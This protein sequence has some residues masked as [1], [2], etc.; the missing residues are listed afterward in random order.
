M[1]NS[2]EL[3]V[4]NCMMVYGTI[5]KEKG[6][7]VK[8]KFWGADAISLNDGDVV[9]LRNALSNNFYN[10]FETI[11]REKN[12]AFNAFE[13]ETFSN[14]FDVTPSEFIEFLNSMI[15]VAS[16]VMFKDNGDR[17]WEDTIDVKMIQVDMERF[18]ANMLKY[19]LDALVDMTRNMSSEVIEKYDDLFIIEVLDLGGR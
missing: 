15:D 8:L 2:F 1:E 11:L 14:V 18:R 3:K 19:I 10:I 6:Y 7:L 17:T 13:L 9:F 5:L 16:R 12:S 4:I